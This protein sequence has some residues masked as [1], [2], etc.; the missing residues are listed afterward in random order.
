MTFYQELQ[1][2]QVGSKAL[3]AS[4]K[5]PKEKL[6]HF[7][8]YLFK[9]LITVAFCVVF[10]TA[11]TKI[12]G[13][14]NSIV[15]VVVLLAVMVFR[16]A[17]FG[18]HTPHAV[19][20]MFA[21]F[22]ILAFGPRLTNM[23]HPVIAFFINII[24]ILLLMILGCHNVIM[25]NHSTFVLGYLLLQGYDVTG[26][27]YTLRLAGLLVGAAVCSFILYRN[28][29]KITYKR[30]FRHLFKE[31]TLHSL[32][33]KWYLRLTFGVST[34]LLIASL[35]EFPRTMW[36]A[37]AAMSVLLPF[38][39]DLVYRVKYRAPGNI[40]GGVL[41]LILYTVLPESAYGTIGM[42]GGIGVGLS[43]SYGWQTVFNSF[44]ALA[45]AAPVFGL[46]E[47][48]FLRIFNNAFGS[49]YGLVFDHAFEPILSFLE[50]N[51]KNSLSY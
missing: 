3:I 25:S 22:G 33:T 13:D 46:P 17:D 14:E 36:A 23:V 28:H 50:K 21:I 27:T 18:I 41:F 37:I 31:F 15:G 26:H 40:L 11:Y 16:F 39:K 51:V 34:V 49:L 32:R 20:V 19:G 48:I 4:I 42:I 43:A 30:N 9:I 12:F 8:I 44:G 7:G 1:L 38:R 35:L 2:N 10:V 47:A 45:I 29:K 6:K 24:C 5:D